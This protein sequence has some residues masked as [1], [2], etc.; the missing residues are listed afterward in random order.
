M[1]MSIAVNED[2]D[3]TYSLLRR[4][5]LSRFLHEE[6]L[7]ELE[8]LCRGISRR[9][10]SGVFRQGE[11]ADTLYWVVEGMVELR[12]KPPGRRVYRTVEVVGRGCIFGDETVFG[13]ERY[14]FSARALEASKLLL[15]SRDAFDRLCTD[16]PR[17]A[18]GVLACAGSCL[19]ETVRRSAVL[20]QAPAE[21]AL[22]HVLKELARSSSR[23]GA[24]LVPVRVTHAQ[25]AGIL[26]LSRET[27]S[28]MLARMATHGTVELGRGMIRV[29]KE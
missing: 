13:E 12:A 7:R 23:P 9:V 17:I 8:V 20:T 16:H 29:R 18:I 2:L 14:L 15:L 22:E 5:Q 28:R 26:H 6:D 19:V 24:R 25:L 1:A 10:G 4:T 21:I 11:P 27:V 3:Q